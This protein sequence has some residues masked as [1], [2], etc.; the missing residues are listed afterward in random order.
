MTKEEIQALISDAL[1][2]HKPAF[3][4]EDIKGVVVAALGDALKGIKDE[5]AALAAKVEAKVE[6]QDFICPQCKK[7]MGD[8]AKCDACGYTKDAAP[9]M[10]DA[11]AARIVLLDTCRPLLN[12]EDKAKALKMSDRELIVAALGDSVKDAASKSDEYLRGMLDSII[13]DRAANAEQLGDASKATGEALDTPI[14]GIA[15]RDL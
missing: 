15:A 9:D 5:V 13:A 11:I 6:D 2:S 14:S 10:N 4:D 7:A 3:K 8:K 1:A 12:D